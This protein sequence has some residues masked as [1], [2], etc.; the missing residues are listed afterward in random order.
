MKIKL[1]FLVLIVFACKSE[2]EQNLD[3]EKK[4]ESTEL[5]EG[6]A[7]IGCDQDVCLQLRNHDLSNKTFDIY[8][9]NSKPVAGFQCD[10]STIDIT[11]SDEGLL[12][13]HGYQTSTNGARVLSFSM[14]AKL[15]EVGEGVLTKI[16]YSGDPNEICMTQIIFAGAGANKLS[17]NLPD[18]ISLQ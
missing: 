5:L 2:K 18:C 7:D 3:S 1:I 4:S 11:G 8:M 10:F 16:I 6:I 13:E 9:Q 14:Q 12:K 17:N 15:I